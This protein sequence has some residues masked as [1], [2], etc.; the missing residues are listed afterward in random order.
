MRGVRMPAENVRGHGP[1]KIS[2]TRSPTGRSRLGHAAA[3]IKQYFQFTDERGNLLD[4]AF[5]YSRTMLPIPA[6]LIVAD[7][8]ETDRARR[9]GDLTG[10]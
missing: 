4:P 6:G 1:A 8:G 2:E 5:F 7:F 10:A 3:D 9:L